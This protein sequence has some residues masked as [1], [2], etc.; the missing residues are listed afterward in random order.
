MGWTWHYIIQTS[1]LDDDFIM[2][3]WHLNLCL[4]DTL[5]VFI[6]ISNVNS[7][8]EPETS[9]A[10]PVLLQDPAVRAVVG[11]LAQDGADQGESGQQVLHVGSR[12]RTDC[13]ISLSHKVS[14]PSLFLSEIKDIQSTVQF[15]FIKLLL[16]LLTKSMYRFYLF[17]F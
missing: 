8:L 5:S 17:F 3:F 15:F 14:V 10:R 4:Y 7:A 9:A 11:V 2:P 1:E 13:F 6:K 12:V 16:P